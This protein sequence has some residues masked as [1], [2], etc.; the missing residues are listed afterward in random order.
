MPSVTSTSP[1]RAT[2]PLSATTDLSEFMISRSVTLATASLFSLFLLLSSAAEKPVLLD[3]AGV[4]SLGITVVPDSG[5]GELAGL[6]GEFHLRI[7]DGRHSYTLEYT[8]P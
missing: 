2:M 3:E 8:L 1:A 7:E 4:Q 6:A 5:T